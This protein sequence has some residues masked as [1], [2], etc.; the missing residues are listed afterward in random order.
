MNWENLVSD[1]HILCTS[2]T[3]YVRHHICVL[4]PVTRWC[5]QLL[6]VCKML[7][8]FVPHLIYIN[9]SPSTMI[10]WSIFHRNS[11]CLPW[12]IISHNVS[13]PHLPMPLAPSPVLEFRCWCCQKMLAWHLLTPLAPLPSVG[14]LLLT[15]FEGVGPMP[16]NPPRCWN[17]NA[18]GRSWSDTFWHL[19][20]P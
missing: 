13:V 2:D 9:P 11:H 4:I 1:V 17:S 20:N 5:I 12:N 19:L 15:L 14:V 3:M 10:S 8:L 6:P 16:S 18:V 7:S